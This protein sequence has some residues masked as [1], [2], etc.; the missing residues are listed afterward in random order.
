MLNVGRPLLAVSSHRLVLLGAGRFGA[1]GRTRTD[2][3]LRPA[4]FKSAASTNSATRAGDF[5]ILA[6]TAERLVARMT[7]DMLSERGI[8]FFQQ[9]FLLSSQEQ[10]LMKRT[11]KNI[12]RIP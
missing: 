11:K 7:A 1:Q 9:P 4:D 3:A 10:S 2:T 6:A 5:S 8:S 12:S